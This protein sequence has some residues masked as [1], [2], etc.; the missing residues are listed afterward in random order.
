VP[1]LRLIV[2]VVERTFHT[3][4][5]L[6]SLHKPPI[7]EEHVHLESDVDQQTENE[8]SEKTLPPRSADGIRERDRTPR[9]DVSLLRLTPLLS[10]VL[11]FPYDLV[12]PAVEFPYHED[13]SN[14]SDNDNEWPKEMTDTRPSV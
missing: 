4:V 11:A 12:L 3:S 6:Q 5:M 2:A 9:S 1:I 13:C 14:R 8:R 10:A 7:Q